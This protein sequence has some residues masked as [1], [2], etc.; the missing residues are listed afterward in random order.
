MDIMQLI[1]IPFMF[2]VFAWLLIWALVKMLFYPM[3]P[4]QILG[5]KW[6]ATIHPIIR[7]TPWQDLFPS[8]PQQSFE[9]VKPFIDEQLD[10]FFHQK[11]KEKLPMISM[12]IGEKTISELKM[13]FMQELEMLFPI[14]LNKLTQ[15]TSLSLNKKMSNSFLQ[16]METRLFKATQKLRW[17]AF[18]CGFLWGFMT[19]YILSLL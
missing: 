16:I 12:F 15:Q 19:L 2:G 7:N 8:D 1:I 10:L 3:T 4:I 13:V 14:L 9:S 11:I 6:E 17:I 18:L 5:F